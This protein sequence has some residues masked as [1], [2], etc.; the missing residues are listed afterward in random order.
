MK[1][2]MQQF[3]ETYASRLWWKTMWDWDIVYYVLIEK[4]VLK[5]MRDMKIILSK[6]T[7]NKNDWQYLCISHSFRQYKK[8]LIATEKFYSQN[9]AIFHYFLLISLFQF[10]SCNLKSLEL[11][12]IYEDQFIKCNLE[13]KWS[14]SAILLGI[15]RNC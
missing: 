11:F 9:F 4:K 15:T 14:L 10:H 5:Y 7:W 3:K 1:C 6:I 12:L 13:Q 8:L 2:G